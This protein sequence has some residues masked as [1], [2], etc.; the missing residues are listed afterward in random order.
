MVIS[1]SH[2]QLFCLSGCKISSIGAMLSAT[3]GNYL[4]PLKIKRY[5]IASL[6]VGGR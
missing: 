2:E 4:I 1:P 6:G 5:K 3:Y